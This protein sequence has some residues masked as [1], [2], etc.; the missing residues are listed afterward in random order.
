MRVGGLVAQTITAIASLLWPLLVL[1]ILLLFRRPLMRVVRS[2]EQR[3]WTLEVGGQKISMK[4]LSDQQNSMIE[5]LQ[6]QVVTQGRAIVELTADVGLLR[7]AEPLARALLAPA[8][9]PEHGRAPGEG[10]APA[11]AAHAVL[12][13]DDN[14]ENNAL[15]IEQLLR[16]GVRV[17][18]AA[19]TAEGL[20]RFRRQRYGA[21][22]SDMR[23]VED[24]TEVPD[25][26]LR[27][28]RAVRREDESIPFMIYSTSG[29]SIRYR[30]QALA[31]GA[32]EITASPVI[33]SE[34]LQSLGLL[35]SDFEPGV[36]VGQGWRSI[37]ARLRPVLSRRQGHD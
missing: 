36:P 33:V 32:T 27:L 22:V 17:D 15:L 30:D 25:A 24:G 23:R 5:D 37:L 7:D 26:G 3:E 31:V 9:Q 34:L 28:L 12:W 8:Q 16:N 11:P 21:I 6:K 4:Q 18:R 10:A 29:A 2:A 13:V 20:E 1:V 14:P 19:S 35:E